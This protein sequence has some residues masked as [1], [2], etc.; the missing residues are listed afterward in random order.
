VETPPRSGGPGQ[1]G[2][3]VQHLFFRLRQQL[4]QLQAGARL[5]R[6][7]FLHGLTWSAHKKI[8]GSICLCLSPLLIPIRNQLVAQASRLC[9]RVLSPAAT[10]NALYLQSC[11]LKAENIRT[12]L[13]CHSE[14]AKGDRSIS[15][16]EMLGYAQH[17]KRR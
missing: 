8:P 4:R 1:V 12:F 13:F 9:R 15:K 11:P 16:Y 7:K 10:N 6:Q 3:V 5:F 14:G 17:D 2:Q